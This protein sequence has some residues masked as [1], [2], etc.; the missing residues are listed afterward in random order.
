MPELYKCAMCGKAFDNRSLVVEILDP[1]VEKA[2][3]AKV[4][5]FVCYD[6]V[7]KVYEAPA[8]GARRMTLTCPR[9]G[10]AV[11]AWL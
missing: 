3:K 8:R 11:E 5:D 6:C 1:V 10:E 7:P 9:C 4:K 2:G